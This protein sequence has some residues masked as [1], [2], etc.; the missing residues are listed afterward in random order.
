[1]SLPIIN[2]LGRSEYTA[3]EEWRDRIINRLRAEQ[4]LL[5]VVSMG[6]RY[7]ASYGWPS[8]FTS[9]DPA[10][11]NSLTGLVQQLRGT[12]AQVLVLGPI[13]YPHTVVPI[14]LSGH[15]DDARACAPARSA[16][17]NDSGIAAEAAATKAAGGHYADVTDLFCTAKRC[18]AIVGNTL[19]YYDASHL[20]LEYS[21]LLAPAI[22]SLTDHALAPG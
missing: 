14:C 3:C 15:L 9:Y 7:G 10:W 8:G 2:P 13:S 19:V 6:R 22:G 20:T 17:V 18:P 1:M 16:A 21:R 5:V 12:G 4:P 11:L